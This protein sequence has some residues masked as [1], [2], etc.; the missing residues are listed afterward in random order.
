MIFI[1]NEGHL[2]VEESQSVRDRGSSLFTPEV[3]Q[4][5]LE[6]L[7]DPMYCRRSTRM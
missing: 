3:R 2:Q 6:I 5:F 7:G 4:N 1:D